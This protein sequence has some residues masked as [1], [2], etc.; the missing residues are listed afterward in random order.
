M[1]VFQAVVVFASLAGCE[2][3]CPKAL[4]SVCLALS[5]LRSVITKVMRPLVKGIKNRALRP[6][7]P[8]AETVVS[9]AQP[10]KDVEYWT[11]SDT[12][13]GTSV[14]IS[15]LGATIVELLTPAADGTLDD[16]VLGFDDVD[17]YRT[18]DPYFG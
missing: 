13:T 1:K 15:T 9:V 16:V 2:S 4:Q 5:N 11:L 6:P 17:T 10:T 3:A 8:F 12:T 14:T 7:S 18:N